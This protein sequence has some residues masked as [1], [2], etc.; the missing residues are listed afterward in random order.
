MPQQI[1]DIDK[2][3][4]SEVWNQ[5]KI[6]VIDDIFSIDYI[7]HTLQP[8]LPPGKQG[9]KQMVTT[10]RTAFPDL[11]MI[12]DDVIVEG[13]KIVTRWILRGTHKGEGLGFPATNKSVQVI[14]IGIHVYKG[15]KV[16]D[17]WTSM[18]SMGLAQ[19]LGMIPPPR[20]DKN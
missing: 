9:L 12:P 10:M 3:L 19:Q 15:G 16:V 8:G 20:Q 11:K 14:G 1:S 2:R 18:D 17:S 6:D 7:N 4:F 13:N 5:G